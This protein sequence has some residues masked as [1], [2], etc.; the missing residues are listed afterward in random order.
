MNVNSTAKNIQTKA[1]FSVWMEP[2]RTFINEFNLIH[3]ENEELTKAQFSAHL[4]AAKNWLGKYYPNPNNTSN[5][6]L[7]KGYLEAFH[8]FCR[9]NSWDLASD[10]LLLD[11]NTPSKKSIPMQLDEWGFFCEEAK[12]YTDLLGRLEPMF[13]LHVCL[14]GLNSIYARMG[15]YGLAIEYEYERLRIAKEIQDIEMVSASLS[16][17]GQTYF[18]IGDYDKAINFQHQSL[19]HVRKTAYKDREASILS[20]LAFSYFE[21]G[22][23]LQ[24][25]HYCEES[26]HIAQEINSYVLEAQALASL[27]LAHHSLKDYRKAIEI[28]QR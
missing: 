14:N 2:G 27:A 7:L 20:S 24:G 4:K 5:L 22:E 21:K 26:L 8:H 9:I 18:I 15:Q 6:E 25:I 1:E 16:R 10:L 17:L 13:D 11:F 23:Y 28:H 3:I 12:L 19:E